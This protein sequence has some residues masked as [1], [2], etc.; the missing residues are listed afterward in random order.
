MSQKVS[1]LALVVAMTATAAAQPDTTTHSATAAEPI[2]VRVQS[3]LLAGALDNGV[4]SFKG[5]PAR[6][7]AGRRASLEAP[8][9]G[10]RMVR[11]AC[12]R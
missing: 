4:E 12:R 8:A 3:G 10:C 5:V 7:A 9:T 2:R 1:A 11:R 6:D